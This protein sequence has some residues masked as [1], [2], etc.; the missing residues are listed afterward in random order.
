MRLA[1]HLG[2]DLEPPPRR[3]DSALHVE[4]PAAG[5]AV[6][7]GRRQ[8]RHLERRGGHLTP[9]DRHPERL[10]PQTRLAGTPPPPLPVRGPPRLL[11]PEGDVRGEDQAPTLRL[12]RGT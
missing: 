6:G 7:N 12:I 1:E 5:A 11:P 4:G 8:I 9:A 3:A 2:L 10:P